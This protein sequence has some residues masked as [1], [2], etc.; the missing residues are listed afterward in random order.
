MKSDVQDKEGLSF[1]LAGRLALLTG[2]ILA[3]YA[4][5]AL[6]AV[7]PTLADHYSDYPNADVLARLMY[8]IVGITLAIAAPIVGA[9]AD[10]YGARRVLLAALVIYAIAGS[11]PFLVTN[12]Y[13]ALMTRLVLGVAAA[14][15]GA[16]ALVLLVQNSTDA[17][18]N[19]WLGY[20]NMTV[21]L[22][23]MFYVPI[24]GYLGHIDWRWPFATYLVAIVVYVLAVIGI[25]RDRA[26]E[27]AAV[28]SARKAANQTRARFQLGTPLGYVAFVFLAGGV[29]S[30]P[31]LY[32]PFLIHD[33]GI[34]DPTTIGLLLTP[35]GVFGALL[36]FCY[37]WTRR[38]LSANATFV[39]GFLGVAAGL[40]L[41]ATAH[42]IVQV[43]TGS[44]IMGS[45]MG[46]AT[47]NVYKLASVA[48]S[49]K[50]RART[51]GFAKSGFY[52]GGL[53]A[54]VFIDTS[55]GNEG[56]RVALMAIATLAILLAVHA[57]W[58]IRWQPA[59][60]VA[61]AGGADGL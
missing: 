1:G 58:R 22:S 26:L 52:G 39:V 24:V 14:G 49:D 20:V 45:G 7:L 41:V 30:G 43:L 5:T 59:S 25:P 8:S 55:L 2:L 33:I 51:V 23:A 16:V 61:A 18:R 46:L 15:V 44:V 27:T 50:Y 36:S 47:P 9:I 37:G 53:L 57:T 21:S 29:L 38:R 31:V 4:Q 19:R 56:P 60:P 10:R 35:L 42:E 6:T 40:T 11:A 3:T 28:K 13:Y 48:G 17:V 12:P 54:Q 32:L 34:T